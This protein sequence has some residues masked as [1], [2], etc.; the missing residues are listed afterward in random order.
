MDGSLTA[1]SGNELF[2]VRYFSRQ[3]FSHPTYARRRHYHV[4]LDAHSDA[5]VFFETRPDRGYE[6]FIVWCLWQ[7]IERI[8]TNIDTRLVREY[9]SR[10]QLRVVLPHIVHVHSQPM[11]SAVHKPNPVLRR[12]AIS[13]QAQLQ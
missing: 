6:F 1:S 4:V 11:R 9:H 10:F 8:W 12:V 2:D 13:D 5:A 7:V 3:R